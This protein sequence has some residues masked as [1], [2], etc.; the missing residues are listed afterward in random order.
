MKR[1]LYEMLGIPFEAT[2]EQIQ[3]AYVARLAALNTSSMQGNEDAVNET[4]MLREGY[5]ILTDPARKYHYDSVLSNPGASARRQVL[6][7]PNDET[8][9]KK[10]GVQTVVLIVVVAV[11]SSVVYKHFARKIEEMDAAHKEAITHQRLDRV[12]KAV[13]AAPVEEEKEKVEPLVPLPAAPA[14]AVTEV[15]K[16]EQK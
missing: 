1:S 7:M 11:L 5:Q 10:L 4:R 15:G 8:M 14:P 3:A 13:V 9:R 6:F 2:S 12:P 16:G